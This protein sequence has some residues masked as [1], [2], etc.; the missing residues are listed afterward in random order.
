MGSLASVASS[1]GEIATFGIGRSDAKQKRPGPPFAGPLRDSDLA[2]KGR[3]SWAP[4]GYGICKVV[5]AGVAQVARQVAEIPLSS[6]VR[7]IDSVS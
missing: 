4:G 1:W 7:M 2:A 6:I 5:D 3:S